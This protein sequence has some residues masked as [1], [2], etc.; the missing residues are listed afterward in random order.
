MKRATSL[1]TLLV[2]AACLVFSHHIKLH[3]TAAVRR[4]IIPPAVVPDFSSSTF[5]FSDFFFGNPTPPLFLSALPRCSCLRA[6][7]VAFCRIFC[8][9]TTSGAS[10]W[11]E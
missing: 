6:M 5:T 10:V 8:E 7:H 3:S 9:G 2:L 4:A 11:T 1:Q